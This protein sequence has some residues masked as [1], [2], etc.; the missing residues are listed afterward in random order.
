MRVLDLVAIGN[1]RRGSGHQAVL[2]IL[3]QILDYT[4]GT[5]LLA[6]FDI[7]SV[8]IVSGRYKMRA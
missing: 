3:K 1:S 8:R 7:T 2:Q 5:P 6:M 4:I